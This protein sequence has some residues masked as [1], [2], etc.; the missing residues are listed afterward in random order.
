MAEF[1]T[2]DAALYI[3]KR[4]EST[5]NTPYTAGADFLK[6]TPDTPIVRIPQMQK[7]SDLGRAGSRFAHTQCN[8]YWLSPG[9]SFAED[10]N[11][12]L[13]GRLLLRALGGNVTTTTVVTSVAFKHTNKM[14]PVASGLQLPGSTVISVN[15]GSGASFLY[16][17]CIVDS[18]EMSQEGT[19][20]VKVSFD[21]LGTGK[22]RSPHAVTSLPSTPSFACLKSTAILNYT[23]GGGLVDLTSGCKIRN[24]RVRVSN[25]HNPVDDR[26][27][28]DPTQDAADYTASGGLSDAAYL[29]KLTHGDPTVEASITLLLDSTLPEWLQ[30][31]QNEALTNITFGAVGAELDSGG[32]TNENLKV[33]IPAGAFSA[34]EW[35]DS[36]GKAAVTLTFIAYED[37]SS[38]SAVTAEVINGTSSNFD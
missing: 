4:K 33:I 27:I 32:P 29:Q 16:P 25:N 21:M 26:C 11:F 24:W 9:I 2:R 15:A 31:A 10:A 7:R 19:N 1:R 5:F 34:V 13:A 8:E 35:T 6:A 17:G 22:H 37:G 23:D 38:D 36:N 12:D 20:P 14:L 3:S 30:M 18:F 28:G